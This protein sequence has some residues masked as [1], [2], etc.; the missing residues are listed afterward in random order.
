MPAGQDKSVDIQIDPDDLKTLK[1][2]NYKLCFAKKVNDTYNVVWQSAG[3]Y[4]ADNS[5]A[6]QPLYRLFGSNSFSGDVK[7]R[8]STNDVAI[9]LGDQAV[10]DKEGILHDASTGGPPTEITMVNQFGKIH[11]GLSAYSTDVHGESS[12]TPIYVAEKEIVLGQDTLTPVEAVQV[13]FEQNIATSTMFSDARSNAEEID[14][15]TVNTAARLYSGGK[16]STPTA[17]SLYTDP[18]TVL[19]I[20][21]TLTAAVSLYDLMTKISSRLTGV[22]K[23]FKA[24]VTSE[25]GTTV[26]IKYKEQPRLTGARLTQT[27]Q[28][29][30]D[31]KLVDQLSDIALRAFAQLNVGYTAMQAI[32]GR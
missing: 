20:I 1:D 14:L 11:P 17:S 31:P 23:D 16:W 22:Y 21:A 5:F 2:N 27:R 8:V 30:Q 12:T 24:E 10:L 9:G 6:W 7:V 28:L 4:L 25:G 15:T 26:K 18:A 13:W 19:T 3:D 29:Q 32:P